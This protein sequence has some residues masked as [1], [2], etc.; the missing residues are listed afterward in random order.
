M[1][2][3][4][5]GYYV[6]I[7]ESSACKVHRNDRDSGELSPNNILPRDFCLAATA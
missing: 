4:L 1:Q 5:E 7:S 6:A 3:S 2:A